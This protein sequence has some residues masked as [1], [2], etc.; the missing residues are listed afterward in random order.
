MLHLDLSGKYADVLEQALFNG[1]LT[2]LSRDG[3]HYFYS[4]P[5]ESDGRHSRWAWHTCPCC[6]M[7]ASR[8]IASVGGYFLS[9]SDDA[10]AFHLYGG[11]SARVALVGGNVTI[12][13]TST[14]PWSGD[15]RIEVE[16][17]APFEF[18]LKLRIPGWAR[19]FDVAVNGEPVASSAKVEDG[20]LTISRR[21]AAGDRVSL[22]LPMPPE[23][24]YAHP[25]VR[26]NV[27]R[28]ALKRGP[29]VYCV[30]EADNP[31]GPVQRLKL[32]REAPLQ[33]ERRGDLFGGII[34]LAVPGVRLA[35]GDWKDTLYR[36]ETPAESPANVT[37]LPYYLWN[38]RGPGSMLVWLVEA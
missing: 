27:G 29:L 23:R 32:P 38:N 7:N 3:T 11:I 20:Y 12:R 16:P 28:F 33:S 1:A 31:G 21:W 36:P 2:G 25:A 14:Y 30:E 37:A 4:N 22:V 24:I 13:E 5:L 18:A 10:I 6:T 9:H 8:L 17:E 19:G 26:M 34:T 15:I 35:D